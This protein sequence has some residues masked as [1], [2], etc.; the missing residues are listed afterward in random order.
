MRL[1]I[2]R[3]PPNFAARCQ[4]CGQMIPAGTTKMADLD[5]HTFRA[6]LPSNLYT[7]HRGREARP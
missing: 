5:G 1:H 7:A 4:T 2:V 3:E 6:L